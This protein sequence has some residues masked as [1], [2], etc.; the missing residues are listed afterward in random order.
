MSRR[1]TQAAPLADLTDVDWDASPEE[2]LAADAT[3][4]RQLD[5]HAQI[6]PIADVPTTLRHMRARL[7]RYRGMALLTFLVVTAGAV[8]AAW[9]P[10]LIGGAVDLVVSG[11]T[12]ADL[13]RQGGLI[14][15]AGV[16]QAALTALGW[17]LVSALGQRVL[18]GM[19]EDVID[20]ALDLPAQTM[21]ITGIGD[22]LSRVADDVDVTAR[23]VNNVVP[24]LIQMGFYVLVTMLGMVTLSPWLLILLAVVVP[25]Y[26]G[27]AVWYL[28]RTAPIYRRERV[29]MG[30]RAQGLLSA[31]HGIP[32]VHAYGIE[33]RE[34]RHVAVL[35]EAA[36]VLGMR[37]MTMVVRLVR[38][39]VWPENIAI[40]L[41]LI[42][43]YVMVNVSGAPV[44]LVTAAALYLISLLWPMMNLIF[45]LD[46]VQAAAASLT[47]MVGVIE[48]I[49][50]AA[51]PGAE[52]PADASIRL[53]GVS[54]AY[55]EDEDGTEHVVLQPIDLDIAAGET[56][57]LVGASGAGKST[58]A[59]ILAGT[60]EPRHGRV[61]HGGADLRRA[62]LEAIRSHASIVSQDVH[63]F[64]G[65]LAEDLR[66]A[67]PEATEEQLLQALRIVDAEAWALELPQGLDTEVG[68]KGERLTAEQSQ[69]LALARIALQD[70]QVLILD[71]ATADEGSSGARVLER[72]ALEVARGRTTVIVAHRLSQAKEADRILVMEDGS[73]VEQGTH[74]QL[75]ALG[76]VYGRL[77]EAWSG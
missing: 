25:M 13:W 21:E 43:G 11:A 56:I 15:L 24:N 52:V 6:L 41:V 22:A 77:W 10:R 12:S 45:S 16:L 30:A 54:H 49:D 42:L 55:L 50:P 23:A 47:R 38:F 1:S 28:R 20:R 31:I 63:V 32:T 4:A 18:A 8:A 37:V 14:M 46:D 33:R 72:A 36:V 66:L 2:L 64:R 62:A 74:E 9:M 19:R 34:T 40:A 69:Q 76:G 48:T 27:A 60:L 17:S 26:L 53:R 39:M 71:E 67:R 65:T 75:V 57:A 3:A 58:L 35:S 70:P 7:W 73:V 29:A 44:G 61:L 68:E 5:E 59:S 51:S